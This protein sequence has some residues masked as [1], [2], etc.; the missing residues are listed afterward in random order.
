MNVEES[1]L[2]AVVEVEKV[3]VHAV[4]AGDPMEVRGVDFHGLDH[5]LF[6]SLCPFLCE[7]QTLK[8]ATLLRRWGTPNDWRLTQNC[9]LLSFSI[10]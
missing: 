7:V 9:N 3:G 2:P 10:C 4:A 6:Q 1:K 8:S 5:G